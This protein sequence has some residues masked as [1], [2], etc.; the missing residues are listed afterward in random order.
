MQAQESERA[1]AEMEQIV[2]ALEIAPMVNVPQD[3]ASRVMGQLPVRRRSPV[4]VLHRQT[5]GK[6]AA[7]AG[8]ALL[9]C[10][11]VAVSPTAARGSSLSV[12]TE[13]ACCLQLLGLMLL[14]GMLRRAGA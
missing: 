12:A 11:M 7:F 1:V 5:L 3:F 10:A 9:L 6:R 14:I 8:V 13:W 4:T 2:R